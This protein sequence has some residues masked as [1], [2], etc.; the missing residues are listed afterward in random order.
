MKQEKKIM[1]K[2][3]NEETIKIGVLGINNVGKTYILSKIARIKNLPKGFSVETKGISVKYGEKE[4]E[5]EKGICILDTEGHETPLLFEKESEEIN[6]IDNNRKETD[7]MKYFNYDIK[8][9]KINEE[10][11]RDKANTEE[12]IEE[13]ILSLSDMIILVI[14]K[15]TR[16]EQRMMTRIKNLAKNNNIKSIIV[17]HNLSHFTKK[18]EVERYIENY[19][20]RSTTFYLKKNKVVGIEEYRER[21][22]Y[23]EENLSSENNGHLKIYHYI[24]AKENSEAGNFYNDLTFKLIEQKYNSCDERKKIDIRT[25]IQNQF[26]ESSNRMVNEKI[27]M[28][29][30]ESLDSNRIKLKNNYI[31]SVNANEDQ[32]KYNRNFKLNDVYMDQEGN[33]FHMNSNSKI[34]YAL[35]FYKE[36][37]KKK[38]S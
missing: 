26:C 25:Q 7:N 17:I 5:E 35:Y 12:F 6:S 24:M 11:H 30:F 16:V 37:V 29:Q 4:K 27:S 21:F 32:H 20:M 34:K 15:M 18:L 10:L 9:T 28:S 22:Y 1:I 38:R 19:L 3:I 23:I 8:R 31:V 2:I 33:Y 13:C 36:G 14:G